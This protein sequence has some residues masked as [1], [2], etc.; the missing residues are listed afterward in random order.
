MLLATAKPTPLPLPL[1]AGAFHIHPWVGARSCCI[2]SVSM[3]ATSC[4]ATTWC[5]RISLRRASTLGVGTPFTAALRSEPRSPSQFSVPMLIPRRA[6]STVRLAS[7]PARR[8]WGM[9]RSWLP[10]T[11][12]VVVCV[13]AA[14]L[15]AAA[16]LPICCSL[17]ASLARG[18]R[19]GWVGT[20]PPPLPSAQLLLPCLPLPCSS[21][22]CAAATAGGLATML[23]LRRW[24]DP[25]YLGRSADSAKLSPPRS[26][27]PSP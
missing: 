22:S 13:A 19:S 23:L 1:A 18:W 15:A 14:A 20:R 7:F 2:A 9:Q 16:V 27:G 4:S 21:H 6:A 10:A 12:A 3:P 26:V 25:R 17:Q 24:A 5:C 11:Y 8:G